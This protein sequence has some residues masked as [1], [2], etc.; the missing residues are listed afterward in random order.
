MYALPLL[1][2][3]LCPF[4]STKGN[5][6]TNVGDVVI[7]EIMAD[8]TPVV[9]LPEEEYIEIF[10]RTNEDIYLDGW[11]I[12][13]GNKKYNFP[14][15]TIKAKE[16]A[17]V[18][19]ISD[20]ALFSKYGNVLGIK[21]LPALPNNGS[22]IAIKDDKE[23]F[24]HGVEYTSDWYNSSLKAD[25]GWSL[26]IVDIE[27]P[28]NQDNNWK[29][30]NDISG[31]TPGRSNSVAGSCA[32]MFFEGITNV[33]PIDSVN[34][35]IDFSETVFGMNGTKAIT[36]NDKVVDSFFS[37]D[38][39]MR[40]FMLQAPF[41]MKKGEKYILM[42]DNSVTDY[43]KNS[44]DVKEF[45]FGLPEIVE[46]GDIVFNEI[47]FNPLRGESDYIEFYNLS[48]KA[49]DMSSLWMASINASGDTSSATQV[50]K[51]N[52]ILMPSSY[53]VITST[54]ES[55]VSRYFTSDKNRIFKATTPSMPDDKGHILLFRKDLTII[56]ELIYTEKLHYSLITNRE[57]IS[58]EKI[59]PDLPS[60]EG[61]SWHSATETSGFG[62]PGLANSIQQNELPA[63]EKR[64][65]LSSSRITP[66][67]DGNEDILSIKISLEGLDN[68]ISVTIF[69]ETGK[70][71]RR[72][73]ENV[74]VGEESEILWDGT[75]ANGS[76]VRNGIYVILVET[77]SHY[78][79]MHVDKQVCTVLRKN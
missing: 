68:V 16:Y 42:I 14:K 77:Y 2:V 6:P 57:G 7:T 19:H 43:A 31:G 44:A 9:G 11:T 23:S 29:A 4:Y 35:E 41:V 75:Y 17:V 56:D 21:S 49:I 79:D 33:F 71:I 3:M 40:K 10:N 55:V 27:N 50:Y 39:L 53:F 34:I 26:E 15:E 36:I 51:T 62:T 18:C 65:V 30:S 20:T 52:F 32:D 67:N 12:I 54:P 78:G 63:S 46:K 66:D 70:M 13:I 1:L 69:S 38:T 37:I 73:A 59:R 24:I 8:P 74:T 58:L 5:T 48:D 61:S 25:G 64:V 45:H 76:L 47:L 28:F 72:L 60:Y 22:T